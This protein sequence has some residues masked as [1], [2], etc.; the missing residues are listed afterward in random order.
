MRVVVFHRPLPDSFGSKSISRSE[1][2]DTIT[3]N[4]NWRLATVKALLQPFANR[5]FTLRVTKTALAIQARFTYFSF[6][7]KDKFKVPL[8]P[9]TYLSFWY[10]SGLKRIDILDERFNRNNA[11][12]ASLQHELADL[13]GVLGRVLILD[14]TALLYLRGMMPDIPGFENVIVPKGVHSTWSFAS[15]SEKANDFLDSI[16]RERDEAQTYCVYDRVKALE[17]RV[18]F[19]T[20]EIETIKQRG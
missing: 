12:V 4:S 15:Y 6:P 20:K 5:V 8:K 17:A 13:A 7:F 3:Y 1:I 19:L 9:W 16:Q 14:D 11:M 2:P 18:E 10:R